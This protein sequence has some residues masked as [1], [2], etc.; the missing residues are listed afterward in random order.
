MFVITKWTN[1]VLYCLGYAV[2]IKKNA[3]NNFLHELLMN[4][5]MDK[6]LEKCDTLKYA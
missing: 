1:Q 3:Y 2:K 6:N 4:S 5:R